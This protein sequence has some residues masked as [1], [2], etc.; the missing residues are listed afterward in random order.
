MKKKQ[1]KL[2]EKSIEKLLEK[3]QYCSVLRSIE[4]G[5]E[6]ISNGYI[7][8]YS[9]D[10][11]VLQEVEDFRPMGFMVIP[12]ERILEIRH[13]KNAKYYDHILTA[14]GKKDKIESKTKVNLKTWKTVFKSF[15]KKG[16]CIVAE[17]E[18]KELDAFNI[19]EIADVTDKAVYIF[20][21]SAQGFWDEEPTK[22][23]YKNITKVMFDD[24]YVDIF[25]KYTRTRKVK[26]KKKKAA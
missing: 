1:E 21:F 3:R 7:L 13:G 22:V 16:K 2:I 24:R 6:L 9:K 17:C 14:E 26:K 10:F 11:L 23:K 8:D 15:Q 19:G 18:G 25:S 20:Y 12:V 5:S 4:D